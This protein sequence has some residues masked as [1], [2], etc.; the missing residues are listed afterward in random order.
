MI[1]LALSPFIK[2]TVAPYEINNI[3]KARKPWL[4][5]SESI[6]PNFFSGITNNS[7]EIPKPT[8]PFTPFIPFDASEPMLDI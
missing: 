8:R 3:A 7:T 4:S 1:P 2:R 6:S 5:L